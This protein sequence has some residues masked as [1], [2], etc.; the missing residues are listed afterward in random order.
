MDILFEDTT[1]PGVFE[2]DEWHEQLNNLIN[3]QS[4]VCTSG[5]APNPIFRPKG[6][7]IKPIEIKHLLRIGILY[8]NHRYGDEGIDRKNKTRNGLNNS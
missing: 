4:K 6:R 3:E 2:P 1:N 5:Q 7:G 8:K